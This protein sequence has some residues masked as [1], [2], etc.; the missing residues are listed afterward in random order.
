MDDLFQ[1]RFDLQRQELIGLE[2]LEEEI[3]VQALK[4]I[5]EKITTELED[6][7]S[8]IETLNGKYS[9][10]NKNIE[11]LQKLE[12]DQDID[13]TK[14]LGIG[15]EITAL[16]EAEPIDI[17]KEIEL[18]ELAQTIQKAS[19]SN[20]TENSEIIVDLEKKIASLSED[21]QN[22]ITALLEDSDL[23]SKI[24]EKRE[25]FN[26]IIDSYIEKERNEQEALAVQIDRLDYQCRNLEEKLQLIK[27]NELPKELAEELEKAK[28]RIELDY[29]QKNLDLE[30]KIQS[31]D[32][33][34]QGQVEIMASQI[35]NLDKKIIEQQSN[36]DK[37]TSNR[38]S[39]KDK[40]DRLSEEFQKLELSKKSNKKIQQKKEEE[41]Q[42]YPSQDPSFIKLRQDISNRKELNSLQRDYES[43]IE[44]LTQQEQKNQ[45][46]QKLHQQ[47][48]KQI[49]FEMNRAREGDLQQLKNEKDE[50]I[51]GLKSIKA[52][53]LADEFAEL[54]RGGE[55]DIQLQ[56]ANELILNLQTQLEIKDFELAQ[57][58]EA[59]ELAA[60]QAQEENAKLV[61]ELKEQKDNANANLEQKDKDLLSA[62][63][64]LEKL[65]QD[66]DK[67]YSELK[68]AQEK[69][70]QAGGKND[71]LNQQVRELQ[72]QLSSKD[73]DLKQQKSE[74]A[75][76][77]EAA[78]EAA[79]QAQEENAKLVTEL[80][81]QK[82]SAQENLAK[83]EEGLKKLQQ[84][85]NELQSELQSAKAAVEKDGTDKNLLNQKI[86]ELEG[87]IEIKDFELDKAKEAAIEGEKRLQKEI[88]ELL[89]KLKEQSNNAQENLAKKD[90]DLSSAKDGL[91]QLQ[92]EKKALDSELKSAQEKALQAGGNNQQLNK[93]LKEL[94]NQLSSK[95]QELT[96]QKSELAQAKEAAAEAA[97]QAQEENAKL[98]TEL[99]GKLEF[100]EKALKKSK[101]NWI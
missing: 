30:K 60:K 28:E 27:Q 33:D 56:Q 10:H 80:Q 5:E 62:K 97:K 74:L 59:A 9:H 12:L 51:K 13:E 22:I 69:A 82:D 66:K 38:D 61:M 68:S 52:M 94:Q 44:K 7:Q 63:E 71:E 79:K 19:I 64:G 88:A 46:L 57:A 16:I 81:G 58:K 26:N 43:I 31:L 32:S 4:E 50:E 21:Q 36:I 65:Q 75:Q 11:G 18:L 83:K 39:T 95:E 78:A 8:E 23:Q 84:Q 2:R 53:S 93:K 92:E 77:K 47:E 17:K 40:I 76:A 90:K 54:D 45:E 35:I 73:I 42:S 6:L 100:S 85:T 87:K 15:K 96:S 29:A 34:V 89:V 99:Q 1:Q 101:K 25:E 37:L 48:K 72:T 14:D 98:V 49:I 91:S 3:Q 24:E 41:I 67:L 20:E 55:L 70:L 86:K